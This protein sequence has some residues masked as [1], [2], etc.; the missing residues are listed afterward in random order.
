[1]AFEF[2]FPDVGE[3]IHEG[4]LVKWLVNEGDFI[5]EDQAIAKIETDKAIVEIP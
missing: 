3:G 2:K 4:E 5:K 1:M